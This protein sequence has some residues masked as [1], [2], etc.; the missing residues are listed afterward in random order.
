MSNKIEHQ[1]FHVVFKKGT[2]TVARPWKGRDVETF[3]SSGCVRDDGTAIPAMFGN[4]EVKQFLEKLNEPFIVVT[5]DVGSKA[6]DYAGT[7]LSIRIMDEGLVVE[8]PETH[9]KSKWYVAFPYLR[10]EGAVYIMTQKPMSIEECSHR[11]GLRVDLENKWGNSFKVGKY[12][13]RLYSHHRKFIQGEVVSKDTNGSVI[14]VRLP[15]GKVISARYAD[16][17][18]LTDGMNLVSTHCLK[19]LGLNRTAGQGLMMTTLSPKGFSKGHGI[20]LP[21]LHHD[22]VLFN[23]KKLL[24]GDQFTFG[25][26]WLHSGRLFTDIQ[27]VLTFRMHRTPFLEEWADI[28]NNKVR[29]ALQDE[30]KLRRV[31]QFYR[32]EFHKY[33]TGEHKD[34]FIEKEKDWALLRALRAGVKHKTHPALVRKLYHLF[35]EKIADCENF[36]IPVPESDGGAREALVDPT[37]FDAHGDPTLEG[38]LQGN[39]VYCGGHVGPIVFHRQPNAHRGECHIA[40]SVQSKDLAALDTGTFLFL[41]RDMV[42]ESLGKLGGGDQDDRLVYYTNPDVVNHFKKLELDPYPIVKYPEAVETESKA[43][44]Y[45]HWFDKPSYT[46]KRFLEMLQNQKQQKVSIGYAVN[47]IMRDTIITDEQTNMLDSLLI[48]PKDH[49]V[50]SAISWLYNRPANK[51][52]GVTSRLELVIDSVKKTGSGLKEIGD[53]IREDNATF[54]IIPLFMT[55]PNKY[56]YSRVPASREN[57]TYPVIVRCSVDDLYDKLHQKTIDVRDAVTTISWQMMEPLPLE[58]LTQPLIPGSEHLAAAIRQYYS[59]QWANLRKENTP[60]GDDKADSKKIISAYVKID[61]AVYRRYYDNPM[62]IDAMVHIYHDVYE[63]ISSEPDKD[64]NGKPKNYPDGILWGPR[65][66]GLTIQMLRLVG[67]AGRYEEAKIDPEWMHLVKRNKRLVEAYKGIILDEKTGN[68]LG[69]VESSLNASNLVLE[70]GPG[71]IMIKM[72]AELKERPSLMSL[73]VMNGLAARK[74][75]PQEIAIWKA[76][77]TAQERVTLIPCVFVND[78]GEQEHAVKVILKSTGEEYGYIS[79]EDASYVVEKTDGWLNEGKTLLS[80]VVNIKR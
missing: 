76:K 41:S 70:S 12:L 8:H 29:D 9:E 45:A 22:L 30:E 32:V 55:R 80:S 23:S 17:G 59:L 28:Y 10:D 19:M 11:L 24:Y 39:T 50:E 53:E 26:D 7:E 79:R 46:R 4:H 18:K 75:S 74:A 61:E 60:T 5:I 51:L 63:R 48:R 25:M 14:L 65:M 73:K 44:Q 38:S 20:V 2:V 67:L 27:S 16:Y 72:P 49:K 66:S 33:V 62:I 47:A 31:L 68:V 77:A 78:R 58:I 35:M 69:S 54:E 15:N 57:E 40:N 43:N 64:E 13:K 71:G 6:D 56:G 36:R 42:A 37:I 3:S 21:H 34:E 1:R 52:K